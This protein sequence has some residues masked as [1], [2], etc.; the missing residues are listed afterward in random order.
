MSQFVPEV[1]Y[2]TYGSPEMSSK[3]LVKSN[4]FSVELNQFIIFHVHMIFKQ[5]TEYSPYPECNDHRI[6]I[7]K[8]ARFSPFH[9]NHGKSSKQS[10]SLI[11]TPETDNRL[12]FAT[13]KRLAADRRSTRPSCD[14]SLDLLMAKGASSLLAPIHFFGD[15]IRSKFSTS[16]VTSIRERLRAKRSLRSAQTRRMK[17]TAVSITWPI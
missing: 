15:E 10:P 13:R 17:R 9:S 4:N 6:S 8:S 5:R 14:S 16:R 12:A 11:S 3:S 7:V 2:F 1:V